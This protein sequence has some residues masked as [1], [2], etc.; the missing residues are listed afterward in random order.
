MQSVF[1]DYSI[2]MWNLTYLGHIICARTGTV[3]FLSWS[4]FWKAEILNLTFFLYL[5]QE[6]ALKLGVLTSEE[7]NNLVVPEKMIGPSDWSSFARWNLIPW[8]KHQL[9]RIFVQKPFFSISWIIPKS[10]CDFLHVP[11]M[12]NNIF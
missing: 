8:L 7:F 12:E 4:L 6:A 5:L 3:Q 9:P 1:Q 10:N 11:I 2:M